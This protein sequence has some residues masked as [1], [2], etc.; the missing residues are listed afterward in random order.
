[1]A[2]AR[3]SKTPKVMRS[4]IAPG[5]NF[6]AVAKF[7]EAGEVAP[8]ARDGVRRE[9]PLESNMA[10]ELLRRLPLSRFHVVRCRAVRLLAG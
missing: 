6:F 10:K 1:M 4:Q 3:G 9:A 5:H 7:R 2:V 8:V